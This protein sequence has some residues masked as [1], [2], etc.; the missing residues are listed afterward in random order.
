MLTQNETKQTERR[1][2]RTEI[3]NSISRLQSSSL[4]L[5]WFFLLELLVFSVRPC[6]SLVLSWARLQQILC[7]Y[8]RLLCL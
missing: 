4:S 5:I 6:Y 1:E 2:G 3:Q 8:A 7:V